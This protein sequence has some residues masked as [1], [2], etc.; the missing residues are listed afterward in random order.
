MEYF[1]KVIAGDSKARSVEDSEARISVQRESLD[2]VDNFRPHAQVRLSA[3]KRAPVRQLVL[4]RSFEFLA[5]GV[6]PFREPLAVAGVVGM[7][8]W[9][10]GVIKLWPAR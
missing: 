4:T 8:Q 10:L 9:F 7:D 1:G 2:E 3:G 5:P 6:P